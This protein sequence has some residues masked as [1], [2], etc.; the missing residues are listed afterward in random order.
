MGCIKWCGCPSAERE[1]RDRM[2]S[3]TPLWSYTTSRQVARPVD[4]HEVR[5]ERRWSSDRRFRSARIGSRSTLDH[6]A[7]WTCTGWLCASPD[8]RHRQCNPS[9][10]LDIP[11]LQH[12]C[13]DRSKVRA[14]CFF[15][16]L[17][18]LVNPVLNRMRYLL[19][20]TADVILMECLHFDYCNL[21]VELGRALVVRSST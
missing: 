10:F 16:R 13:I 14:C 19:P 5:E 15:I 8:D 4:Q 21:D 17:A 9:Q 12:P 3:M 6:S 2:N 7:S 20:T 18:G 11:F 1:S